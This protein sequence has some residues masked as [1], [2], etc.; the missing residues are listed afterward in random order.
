[1]SMEDQYLGVQFRDGVPH[2][3]RICTMSDVDIALPSK[4]NHVVYHFSMQTVVISLANDESK[5]IRLTRDKRLAD[6]LSMLRQ[7]RASSSLFLRCYIVQRTTRSLTVKSICTMH[8]LD[9]L[10]KNCHPSIMRIV[11]LFQTLS[12]ISTQL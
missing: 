7:S 3:L 10:P 1:M 9:A 2:L 5:E 12:S 6:L 4:D 11:V 8:R